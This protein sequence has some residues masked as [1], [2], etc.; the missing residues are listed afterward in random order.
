M[1]EPTP[2]KRKRKIRVE[3]EGDEGAERKGAAKRKV[4]PILAHTDASKSRKV[5]AQCQQPI[6]ALVSLISV[7]LAGVQR[8]HARPYMFGYCGEA[9][10]SPNPR[11]KLDGTDV[12]G[13]QIPVSVAAFGDEDAVLV[14]L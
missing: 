3:G 11:A 5:R 6:T 13:A 10:S 14:P 1:I 7:V 12:T 9:C 2:P 8:C 4:A